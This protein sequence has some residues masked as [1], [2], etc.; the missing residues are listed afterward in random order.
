MAEFPISMN[1]TEKILFSDFDIFRKYGMNAGL[2]LDLLKENYRARFET[3]R[4]FVLLLHPRIIAEHAE[5][6]HQF[7]HYVKALGGQCLT[8]D[9]Y[10]QKIFAQRPGRK[11]VRIDLRRGSQTPEQDAQAFIQAGITD[12]FL[13]ATDSDGNQYY[14]HA[15]PSGMPDESDFS[16][17]QR[18][19]K[20]AGVRVHAW[21]S[22]NRNAKR[23]RQYTA[24]AM[25][26]ADGKHSTE[27]ISPSHPATH[28]H[29]KRTIRDLL[30]GG[31]LDGIHLDHIEYP[32]L[33]YDFSDTAVNAFHND[34]GVAAGS[35]KRAHHL[36]ETHYD[37]WVNWRRQQ[38]DRL[39]T[40]CGR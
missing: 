4:P 13:M 39:G 30:T 27:W 7:I 36:I 18:H 34:T 21:I 5:T 17:W 9:Q 23:A 15:K 6:L 37:E 29:L 11:G 31:D 40:Q 2:A 33:D 28:R 3:G 26:S 24:Q 35:P 1:S 8:F 14:P 10:E 22:V 25:V 19:L 16:I 38:I 32:G 12:A 20:K